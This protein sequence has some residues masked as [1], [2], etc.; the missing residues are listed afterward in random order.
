M[1]SSFFVKKPKEAEVEQEEQ[2]EEDN[3]L[4]QEFR[5]RFRFTAYFCLF[6]IK[7]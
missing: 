5:V 3:K 2:K 1:F 4:F 7:Y 6:C